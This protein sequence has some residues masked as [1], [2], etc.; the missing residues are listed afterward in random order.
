MKA[1][2]LLFVTFLTLS[3]FV[4]AAD[5]KAQGSD[6]DTG[7]ADGILW[8][9]GPKFEAILEEHPEICE[10]DDPSAAL[11]KLPASLKLTKV[12]SLPAH[13]KFLKFLFDITAKDLTEGITTAIDLAIYSACEPADDSLPPD[14]FG[15]DENDF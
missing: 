5:I 3:V 2:V 6:D 15:D 14:D 8:V 4:A 11:R 1:N 12:V 13:R 9:L 10:A 7:G